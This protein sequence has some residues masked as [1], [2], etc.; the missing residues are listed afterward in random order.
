MLG[1]N[2]IQP[3]TIPQ[4]IINASEGIATTDTNSIEAI[5]SESSANESTELSTASSSTTESCQ[6]ASISQASQG[7]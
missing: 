7:T 4:S 1:A 6:D 3:S 5:T 2:V